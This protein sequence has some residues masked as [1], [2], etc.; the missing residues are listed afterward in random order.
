M[1]AWLDRR[2]FQSSQ[3]I[4]HGVQRG[5]LFL[6][7]AGFLCAPGCRTNAEFNKAILE[8]ELRSHEDEIYA[9]EDHLAD[10][11]SMLEVYRQENATLRSRLED[12]APKPSRVRR[13][14][15]DTLP[16]QPDSLIA[17]PV[18]EFDDDGESVPPAKTPSADFDAAPLQSPP[19]DPPFVE[20]SAE[21]PGSDSSLKRELAPVAPEALP[22]PTSLDGDDAQIDRIVS[23]RLVLPRTDLAQPK[24]RLLVE[25]RDGNGAIVRTAGDLSIVLQDSEMQTI[26]RWDITAAE[27]KRLWTRSSLG[28]GRS[29]RS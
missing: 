12:P 21:S 7:A 8:R 5:V 17:P 19:G 6:A 10:C 22:E 14:A 28:Q 2:S 26:E 15:T 25:P 9:L 13:P 24:I 3:S 18:I 11:H 27:A 23:S 4:A 16:D 29:S 1:N 20:P